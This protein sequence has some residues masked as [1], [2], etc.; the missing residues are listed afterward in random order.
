[1]MDWHS[2]VIM[3][4]LIFVAL[5]SAALLLSAIRAGKGR[6]ASEDREEQ[7]LP[8]E[9]I[10]H[11]LETLNVAEGEEHGPS[12]KPEIL[13]IFRTLQGRGGRAKD[14]RQR[15]GLGFQGSG[16]SAYGT[17]STFNTWI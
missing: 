8:Q 2:D 6:D 12:R 7:Y 17:G 13:A 11:F 15:T 4:V 14:A 10:L 5:V 9:A 1:M 3:A 16:N